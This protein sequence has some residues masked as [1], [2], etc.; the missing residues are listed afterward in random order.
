METSRCVSSASSERQIDSRHLQTESS[1]ADKEN[2]GT[3]PDGGKQGIPIS[4]R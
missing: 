2:I 3:A 4:Y 1:E